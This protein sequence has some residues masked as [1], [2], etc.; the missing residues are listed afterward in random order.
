MK[1]VRLIRHGESAANACQPTRD[2]ASIPLTTKG[3]EQAHM[4]ARSFTSAP[5]LIVASPF[6]RA[7]ASN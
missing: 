7:Q 5:D 4:V 3:L 6:H 2:H 1:N